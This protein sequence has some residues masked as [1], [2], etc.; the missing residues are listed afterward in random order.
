MATTKFLLQGK[1][2]PTP[3]YLRLSIERGNTPKR[4][5]GLVI[6]RKDWSTDTNLPKQNTAQN[7]NLN[8]KL[9]KLNNHI[10]DRFNNA[11]S[12][13]VQINGEWLQNEIDAHFRQGIKKNDLNKATDYIDH[14]LS[15]AHL[16]KNG[17]GGIGLGKS[18]IN[19][20]K[21]LKGLITEYERHTPLLIRNIDLKFKDAFL[22]WMT[23]TKKYS[24][25]YAGRTIG[26]LKTVCLD[27]D[28]NGI[29]THKQLPKVSGFKTKNNNI[30]YL[31][32]SE[33]KQIEKVN[34]LHPYLE[35]A[36]KWLLLGCQIGQRGNDM[37]ELTANNITTRDDLPVIEMVQTKT[38]K[39]VTI[40][41]L[42][43]TQRIIKNGFPK[44]ISLQKFNDYIKI[45]CKEAGLN[46]KI[47]GQKVE[48]IEK[49]K[50]GKRSQKRTIEGRYAKWELITSH[51]CRRSF[52]SNH[53]GVIPTPLIMQI[54]GHAQEKTFYGYIGKN[55]YD[56]AQQIADFYKKLHSQEKKEAQMEVIK[57]ISNP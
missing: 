11:Y 32:I 19:S 34:L 57:N 45:V 40:P 31:S 42:R 3:V 26:A 56:Y 47:Q 41:I 46:E 43:D 6:D 54:T 27:A 13:G 23:T 49:G 15:M 53:F 4:K 16:K 22:K 20:Y 39:S 18:T 55:S 10:L 28:F 48:V 9:R 44:K 17:K 24:L 36:R 30:I 7:K 1:S 2:T 33:L 35:N 37:L 52:A 50:N 12:E 21:R 51:I 29:E 38:G 14:F 25:G 5:T 8:S